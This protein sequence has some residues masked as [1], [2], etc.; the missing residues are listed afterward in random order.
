MKQEPLQS[1]REG[2]KAG[3]EEQLGL[4]YESV[5]H[6]FYTFSFVMKM[7]QFCLNKSF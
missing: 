7:V 5:L 1:T 2:K 3:N 6:F 4:N